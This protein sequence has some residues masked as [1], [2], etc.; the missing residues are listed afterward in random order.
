MAT[1][2]KQHA[3]RRGESRRCTWRSSCA[4]SLKSQAIGLVLPTGNVRGRT[5]GA[6]GDFASG[7]PG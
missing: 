4:P 1:R 5:I 2:T 7:P 3:S 6:E